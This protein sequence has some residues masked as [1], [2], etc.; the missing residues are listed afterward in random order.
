M[1]QILQDFLPAFMVLFAVIDIVGAI[2]VI[3]KLEQEGCEIKPLK[4]T[5]ISFVIL[6]VF[7]FTGEWILELFGVDISSFAIAGSLVIFV[8]AFEM[9]FGVSIFKY[10]L[11][12]SASIIPIAFPLIAGAGSITTLIS[13]RAEYSLTVILVALGANMGVVFL[14]L[15]STK[16]IEKVIGINGIYVLKKAFGIIL[17]AIAIKLFMSNTALIVQRD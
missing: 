12:S 9:I 3:L 2:P 6:V 14:A 11:P 13:L 16:K 4:I 5:L 8:L 1:Q 15:S 7:L 17:L 10:E